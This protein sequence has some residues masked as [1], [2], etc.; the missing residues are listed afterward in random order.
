MTTRIPTH[1]DLKR[2]VLDAAAHNLDALESLLDEA[3]E[4]ITDETECD[5]LF[6]QV[7]QLLSEDVREARNWRD[8]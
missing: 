4:T 6:D 1:A 5:R 2:R 7:E 8:A 3:T